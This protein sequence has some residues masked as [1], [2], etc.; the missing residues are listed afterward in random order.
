M[1]SEGNGLPSGVAIATPSDRGFERWLLGGLA[2]ALV[3]ALVILLLL[4]MRCM[5]AGVML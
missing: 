2:V 5:E 4:V 1:N 3:L